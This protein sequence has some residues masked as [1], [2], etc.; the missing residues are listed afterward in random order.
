MGRAHAGKV[1]VTMNKHT[2]D[3]GRTPLKPGSLK[4]GLR[5]LTLGLAVAG[6]VALG[7]C[8]ESEQDRPLD[9]EPGVY[10]GQDDEQLSSD[11][12]DVL[13]DRARRGQDY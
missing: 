5:A 4:P 12:L 6:T 11:T 2:K 8:R 13:R 3:T 9:Y 10:L 1:D 7:G